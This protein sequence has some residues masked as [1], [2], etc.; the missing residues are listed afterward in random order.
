[1]KTIFEGSSFK[2]SSSSNAE[3][4]ITLK[5]QT[6]SSPHSTLF[7]RDRIEDKV[8]LLKN[9]FKEELKEEEEQEEEEEQK[10][11]IIGRVCCDSSDR[12]ELQL[13]SSDGSRVK[14]ELRS[15]ENEYSLFLDRLSSAS[16]RIQPVLL[17][18]E[19]D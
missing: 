9:K 4:E 19:G 6:S 11:Q 5:I 7:M 10:G 14:L 17:R 12:Q 16:A 3:K 15:V 2:S 13:E 8:A 1:M 18:R